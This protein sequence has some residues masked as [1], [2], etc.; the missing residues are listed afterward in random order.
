MYVLSFC[1]LLFGRQQIFQR[2]MT[3]YLVLFDEVWND[4]DVFVANTVDYQLSVL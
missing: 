3:I 4:S 1:V 2:R